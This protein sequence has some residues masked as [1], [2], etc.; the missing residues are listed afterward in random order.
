MQ[1]KNLWYLEILFLIRPSQKWRYE[2]SSHHGTLQ[3]L[4][5]LES[6]HFDPFVST[7][8]SCVQGSIYATV[9]AASQ[10]YGNFKASCHHLSARYSVFPREDL[11]THQTRGW[12]GDEVKD[13]A[14][15]PLKIHERFLKSEFPCSGKLHREC[16][17]MQICFFALLEFFYAHAWPARVFFILFCSHTKTIVH[18]AWKTFKKT[19][20]RSQIPDPSQPVC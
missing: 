1:K 7:H 13:T 17:E 4:W 20:N 15:Q 16:P 10:H 9:W 5:G 19:P 18:K 12:A 2:K 14:V 3:Q 11:L 8:S 6:A